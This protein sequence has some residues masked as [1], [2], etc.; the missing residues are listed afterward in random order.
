MMRS[1]R[2]RCVMRLAP[3]LALL[4]TAAF[5][6]AIEV[7]TNNYDDARTGANLR[8]RVLN[9]SNVRAETFG[10]LFRLPVDGPVY[11]QPL[12]AARVD[13][14]E[15]GVHDVVYVTTGSNS[16]Y[17]FDAHDASALP[18][19]RRELTRL[20]DGTA[21]PPLGIFSTP[22]IDRA[23]RTLYVVAG[24]QRGAE[25]RYVL[26]ALDSADG[27]DKQSGPVVISGAVTLAG[28]RVA[29]QPTQTR[30]AVQ[31]AA[32]AIAQNKVI[33]A[34]GGDYFEGW[35]FAIDKHNL[36]APAATFCTVCASRLPAV[37]KVDY[38]DKD[39][40]LLG[41]G[42]GIWQSGRGP[43]VD[44][45][46]LVYFFT[47]NK[48]HVI[49]DGCRVPQGVNACARCADE[50]GCLCRGAGAGKACRGPDACVAHH[51]G[52]GRQ[53]DVNESLIQLHPSEGLRLTG[54][55][56]PD[57]WDD[58]DV[59][60]LE[61]NDLDLGGS[62][63]VLV[64]GTSRLIGGGKQGVMYQFETARRS[65]ECRPSLDETCIPP[66]LQS[67]QVAPIPPRPHE[68]YRHILGGPVIWMRAQSAGGPLVYLWREND[69]L[70][71]YR[72]SDEFRDCDTNAPA[73]TT[74]HVCPS[75]AQSKEFIDRHPGGI[76]ALSAAGA[77]PASAI[78]WVSTSR[79]VNGPGK[80][81]AFQALPDAESKELVKIWDSDMC[82]GDGIEAGS[83]FVPPTVANGKVYLATAANSV[84]VFGLIPA[85]ECVRPPAGE[86]FGPLLQ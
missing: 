30:I 43:V 64:P 45:Q 37:S 49:K 44:A 25:A 79:A 26:H 82:E 57:N 66:P 59:N 41:P 12:L 35:V 61:L 33:V 58:G 23:S 52:D 74:S 84:D 63:P 8:E 24:L 71:S 27:S 29:F 14:R 13:L 60:G 75:A 6:Q 86:S 53:F 4:G 38:L 65:P 36:K 39:C 47:G 67:F 3:A 18:L 81:M 48:Q 78:V 31:R 2:V 68:F 83:D 80:L 15:K 7:L 72:L 55:F 5:A 56:R 16:V 50:A 21:A 20:P 1:A 73:P 9:L 77:D 70:R 32:L 42:G 85:R 10:R 40:V 19:W 62:G 76:L 22:V 11:G 69:H 51:A 54:W 34:F 28:E 17:A 46:G